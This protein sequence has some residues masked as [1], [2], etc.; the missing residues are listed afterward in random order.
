MAEEGIPPGTIVFGP[1]GNCTLAICPVQHSIYGYRPSLAASITFIVL[2]SIA[3]CIHLFLGLRWKKWG[4]M[5]CML[6]G[7][8][9]AILGYA[10]RIMMWYN[11][12]TFSGFMLQISKSCVKAHDTTGRPSPQYCNYIPACLIT[13]RG[14][15]PSTIRE[16]RPP[17]IVYLVKVLILPGSLYHMRPSFLYSCHLHHPRRSVRT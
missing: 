2:Y 3:A 8:A 10:G 7:A 15:L 11:P 4:F 16:T 13:S 9:D 1:D 17:S 5:S 6:L 14:T 12:F